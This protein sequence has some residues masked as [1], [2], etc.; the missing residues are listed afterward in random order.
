VTNRE[1]PVLGETGSGLTIRYLGRNLYSPT[2]PIASA[3]RRASA[4]SILPETLV[5]VP[6]PLLFYGMDL[7]LASAP[8]GTHFLCVEV[9]QQLMSLSLEHT[10]NALLRHERITYL[11]TESVDEVLGAL[12]GLGIRRFRRCVEA[13]LNGG[14]SVNR[15][16]YERMLRAVEYEIQTHWRNRMT[17]MH[18][19][20]LW[21]KNFLRN[22]AAVSRGRDVGAL[23]IQKPIV[24]AGAGESLEAAVPPLVA[25]RDRFY[26]IAVDTAVRTLQS[27]GLDPDAVAVLD[28]QSA[29]LADLVG[30]NSSRAALISDVSAY[31]ECIR[32]FS[33]ER[34]FFFSQFAELSLFAR[35]R[36]AGILPTAIP[37]L[38]SIGIA[39]L[40][41]ALELTDF[42]VFFAGLDFSFRPGKSHARGSPAHVAGL[43]RS[44]RLRPVDTYAQA[45]QR[46]HRVVADKIGHAVWTDNMLES[47][48][49][50]L[51]FF[52][53]GRG[54]VY[55]LA[56]SG[57]ANSAPVVEDLR[58]LQRLLETRENAP[59]VEVSPTSRR[60]HIRKREVATTD[61]SKWGR[62][63]LLD[64]QRR[65]ERGIDLALGA[66]DSAKLHTDAEASL[67]PVLDEL[68]YVFVHFADRSE[69]PSLNEGFL[70]RFVEAAETRSR[71][72]EQGLAAFDE[73]ER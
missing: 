53:S 15:D 52:V 10:S 67:R 32:R 21:I 47:Y 23:R 45:A 2:S 24:V 71:W 46:P 31:P 68:D 70:K 51:D 26:L 72:I 66:L 22:V 58:S 42:A 63:F 49:N 36:A 25:L 29:N 73:A 20:H 38:G 6:S 12:H 48:S 28:A 18:M 3:E 17:L 69:R 44:G 41:L 43:L 35:A 11:R 30:F 56:R 60:P 16:R 64:E 9:D 4:L 62:A 40:Y 27:L 13:V 37:P 5:F 61:K 57:L 7:L 19:S 14:R 50:A 59:L 39:A 1:G 65:I 55:D 54:R 33:G 34:W 8:E